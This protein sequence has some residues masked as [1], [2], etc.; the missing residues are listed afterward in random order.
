MSWFEQG[1]V[2]ARYPVCGWDC[3][4]FGKV[5]LGTVWESGWIGKMPEVWF[6]ME[7]CFICGKSCSNL[8]RTDSRE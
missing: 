5:P 1:M 8:L 7:R 2:L 6:E 3:G 4:M